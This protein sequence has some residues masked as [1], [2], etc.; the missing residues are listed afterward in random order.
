MGYGDIG[1]YGQQKILT[2]NIDKLADEGMRFTNA[3]AGSAVC[4]PSRSALMQGMHPGHARIRGNFYN[5]YRESL[6]EGDYT[7]AMMLQQA[8]YETGLFGKWGLALNDQYGVPNRMGFHEFFGYLNQRQA[9]NH[10][11]KFLYHNTEKSLLPGAW[12]III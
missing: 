12:S 5:D 1:C 9:H 3:Y 8:G 7:V 4:A 10:Y 11:P 2:P 6:Q